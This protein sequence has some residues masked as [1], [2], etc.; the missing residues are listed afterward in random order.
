MAVLG[1]GF[2]VVTIS[3]FEEQMKRPGTA[4]LSSF[5][6]AERRVMGWPP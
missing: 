5:R 6:P 2:D 1:I 3:E 4:M